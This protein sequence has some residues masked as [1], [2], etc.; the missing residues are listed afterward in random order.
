LER[1]RQALRLKRIGLSSD[2]RAIL[3]AHLAAFHDRTEAPAAA[4]ELKAA[5]DSAKGGL[6]TG[7]SKA[8][9]AAFQAYVRKEK[10]HM[11]YYPAPR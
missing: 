8:G 1:N 4:V 9:W 3:I 10:A 11:T 2:D 6:Q 7:L 5:A